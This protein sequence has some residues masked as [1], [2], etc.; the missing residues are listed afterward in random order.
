MY[1]LE[2]KIPMEDN[3]AIPSASIILCLTVISTTLTLYLICIIKT[4]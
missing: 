4:V 2:S 1:K 3:E